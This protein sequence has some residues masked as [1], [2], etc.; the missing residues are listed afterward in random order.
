MKTI[1]NRVEESSQQISNCLNNTQKTLEIQ[2]NVMHTVSTMIRMIA[3]SQ[4]CNDDHLLEITTKLLQ[5]VSQLQQDLPRQIMM[6]KPVYLED[7]RGVMAP[8]YLEF[9]TSKEV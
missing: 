6:Q 2:H 4:L 9:I 8:F 3:E 7:A 5:A 1:R